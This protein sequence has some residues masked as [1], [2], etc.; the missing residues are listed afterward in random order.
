MVVANGEAMTKMLKAAR[1]EAK[2]SRRLAD[3]SQQIALE[4]KEDSV[5][6]KTVSSLSCALLIYMASLL[7]KGIRLQY[8][9]CSFFPVHPLR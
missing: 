9:P 1:T 7:K 2:I 3:Q 4:M 5:A 6:M 8:L